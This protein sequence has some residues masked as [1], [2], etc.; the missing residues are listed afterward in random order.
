MDSTEKADISAKISELKSKITEA[1]QAEQKAKESIENA[2]NKLEELKQNRDTLQGELDALNQQMSELETQ[3]SEQ[4]PQVQE[5][6]NEYNKAKQ[7]RDTYKTK[8]VS[9]AKSELQSAQSYVGDINSAI[10]KLDNRDVKKEYSLNKYD[11]EEG[12]RLVDTAKQM[13]AEYGESHG[14]CATGVSRTIN[15]AYG[16][17]MGGNGCDWDTNMEKLVEKGMFAE[18]TEEYPSAGDLSSL[19]AGAVVCWEATTGEGN[20]GA[21]YGHVTIADGNGGEISDHYQSSIYKSVGGRS[22]TY[23]IFIPV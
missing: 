14:W 12:Q 3:I 4:Y 6:L 2:E 10:N 9:S 16:I 20:G 17:K 7:S 1:E 21:K 19:P 22:D 15:M 5:S 23:R 13:L 18:V 8:A 11:E